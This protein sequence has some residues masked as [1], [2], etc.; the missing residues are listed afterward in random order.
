MP[1]MMY[2]NCKAIFCEESAVRCFTYKAWGFSLLVLTDSGNAK[3]SIRQ[4][5]WQ[6]QTLTL[7][8]YLIF[9]SQSGETKAHNYDYEK[10]NY[11]GDYVSGSTNAGI[12]QTS[13]DDV[14]W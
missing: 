7:F 8:L 5:E 11:L 12:S 2:I 6:V 4:N 13:D 3:A 14:E 1:T 9:N 10:T